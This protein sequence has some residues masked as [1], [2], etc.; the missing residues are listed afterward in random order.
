MTSPAIPTL[1]HL[2][3]QTAR[4]RRDLSALTNKF[5][6]HDLELGDRIFVRLLSPVWRNPFGK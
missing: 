4:L 2:I 1:A 3:L 6:E 5:P